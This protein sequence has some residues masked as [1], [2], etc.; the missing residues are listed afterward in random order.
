[1]ADDAGRL[2]QVFAETSFL[3]GSN[4]AFIEDLHAQW[5]DDPASVSGEWRDFFNQ[6]RDSA[7]TVKASAG[8][9]AWGRDRAT[10]ATEET[11]VF[12]GRWPTPRPVPGKGGAPAAPAAAASGAT[13]DEV[14]AAA[15]DS[16][17]ALM[18]IRSYRVRGHLHA[19]LDPLGIEQPIDNPELTPE[20]YGF[21][22]ADLDRPI[23][24][25]GVLGLQTGTVREVMALLERTYC[26]TIGIQY[27]HI[28][29]PE[30]KSWLQARIEGPDKFEQNAFTR[31]G[32]LAILNKLIEA[33]G[34]ERFLHKRFPGT[35]RFGLDGGEAMVP[36]MEQIIKRGGA[37]GVD[38]M[39]FGMAHRGRL[40]ML[41][42][43]MAKP[44]RAIFHEFQGGSS[45]PSDIEGSGDVKYHMGASSNREF[46]GNHVHLSLTANPSHLEIVNPVV[47][48]KA[49]AKQAFDI[50]AANAGKPEAE[51]ALDRSKVMPVLIHGDAAFAGQGVVAECFALM[52]LK[53]YRTGGTMHFVVNNQIGFTTSPRN[54]RSSP[55]PSDVALMVQAPIFHVNGDDPEAVVFAAKVAT[56]FRQKFH[57]DVVVD[58][59]CYRRFG[60][61]EGDDPTFTQPLMY[62]KIKAQPSTR[63]I[64]SQRLIDEGV[65]DAA[66][67]DAAIADFDAFLDAQFEAGK[68]FEADKADWM[69]GQWQGI[70]LPEGDERRGK[71]DVPAAKLTD[72]GTRL[73]TVPNQ[74]DIHRTLKRVMEGRRETITTGENIDWATAESLAF[75]TLLDEGFPVRLSGQDSVRGT[76]S[77]RHS[78]VIDQ[79][80][81]ERY[82]PLNNLR[83][84]QAEFEVIDSALSE[85]AVLGFEYGYAVTD[86]NTL[87]MWEAQFGDFVNGAQVVIDQFISSGERKWLRMC[88][89]TMLLPHGY[90]GQGPEHS[91]ARLERFLQQCA[92]DNMQVANCTTPANYF[93][94]LRRQ[95][96]RHFRKPLILM[97]PKSLLRH[98]KAVSSLADMAEGSSFHR[99]LH[100]DA[101]RRPDVAGLTLK[102][103]KDIRRV[104]LCSGKVYYDLLESREVR[105]KA[106]EPVDDVYLMRLEQFYPWPLKSL[107]TELVRFPKAE[108]VW[109]QEEPKNMGGWTFVD[110][111]LELTLEKLDLASTRARYVGRPAS[112]STAAGLMSRHLKELETFLNDAFAV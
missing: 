76:F 70:G 112:A 45:V 1:M 16:I 10:E 54:S 84:G 72:L 78:G 93:H 95:M 73:T 17:R 97:T 77:Q 5:A 11:G 55:Y 36:A 90:E 25:D 63:E 29:E 39:V 110:P 7:A 98:K 8:A 22:E 37:L 30:E 101:E 6:L 12:D 81:E 2:N 52:G 57:K 104:V 86:P 111:W 71:T 47:L 38:E 83:E 91:S 9:G 4:A 64:Y 18:L 27:M 49:R 82:I 59:F 66:G 32:K 24:L 58:M 14:R 26:G 60:H 67:V 56:E 69:D 68:T 99:V 107:M 85:E 20:F 62:A 34:F 28:A 108:L 80:T 3:Y 79:T 75:A 48:G 88:G 92:E 44:Y 46:D 94:I 105:F 42:A 23:Y 109:C 13:T 35:K 100:D 31:E 43:V 15:H 74:I 19:K 102:P 33:E 53:G 51:W 89:L 96:Q 40:N 21:S 106:G 50:R 65:I 87:V 103:D 41:A 61:N